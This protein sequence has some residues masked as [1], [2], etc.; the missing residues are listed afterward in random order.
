MSALRIGLVPALALA[1]SFGISAAYAQTAAPPA[2]PDA[3]TAPAAKPMKHMAKP[4]VHKVSV[5]KAC[6]TAGHKQKLKGDAFKKF[7]ADCVRH[8]GPSA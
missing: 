1:L 2:A 8:G 7:E 5:T 4:T 6:T 3:T